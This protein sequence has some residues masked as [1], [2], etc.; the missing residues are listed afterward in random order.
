MDHLLDG[1]ALVSPFPRALAPVGWATNKVLRTGVVATMPRWMREMGGIRQSRLADGAVVPV[2]KSA[3]WLSHLS[4][5]V[6]LRAIGMLSPSTVSVVAPILFGV[7]PKNPEVLN[8]SDARARYRY[9]KP[10]EAHLDLRAKQ[11]SQLL[12]ELGG[13]VPRRIECH[14]P[15]P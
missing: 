6:E 8:P 4:R 15:R 5:R 12:K 3:F 9:D 1:A 11:G 14:T 13:S 7:P 2:L 10:S